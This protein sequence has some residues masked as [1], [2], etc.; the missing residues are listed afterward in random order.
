[1]TFS[2]QVLRLEVQIQLRGEVLEVRATGGKAGEYPPAALAD[3]GVGA[4]TGLQA[5]RRILSHAC[6]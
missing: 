6:T 4:G 2:S 5:A 3:P 1:M